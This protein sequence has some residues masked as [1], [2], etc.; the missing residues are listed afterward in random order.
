MRENAK[1]VETSTLVFHKNHE[2]FILEN[3]FVLV[4]LRELQDAPKHYTDRFD[5]RSQVAQ[6]QP[7]LSQGPLDVLVISLRIRT[8]TLDVLV[9]L[10]GIIW[11]CQST[12]NLIIN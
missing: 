4:V 3:M 1:N 7:W 12:H 9:I 10:F 5:T 11:L 2:F 6:G 8:W